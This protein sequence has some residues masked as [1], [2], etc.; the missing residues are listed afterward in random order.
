MTMPV[1]IQYNSSLVPRPLPVFNVT[2]R[3]T[4]GPGMQVHVCDA[5]IVYCHV[6]TKR[7]L[8]IS[9]S[10]LFRAIDLKGKFVSTL[11]AS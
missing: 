9:R 1:I 2:C 11:F 4:G 6:C 10:C 8:C 7:S 3:K 5:T